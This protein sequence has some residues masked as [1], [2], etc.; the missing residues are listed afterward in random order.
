MENS[1][2]TVCESCNTLAGR[3]DGKLENYGQVADIVQTDSPLQVGLSGEVKGTPFVVTG[4]A[5]Y[6]HAAGGVWDE[7][8][9]AFHDGK[10][11]GW[12]AEAQ[13]K[14]YLTFPKQLP[15]DFAFDFAETPLEAE[16]EIP[17][18]GRMKV[19]E[20][21]QATA[22][23]AEGE[24]PY[25]FEPGETV[26]YADLQGSNGRFATIDNSD[27]SPSLYLGGEFSL[28]RLGVDPH[29]ASREEEAA[30][31]S[32]VGISCP[33]CGGALEQ[34]CPD[35]LR[36]VCP[37]CDSLLDVSAGGSLKFLEALGKQK[38]KPVIPLGTTGTLRGREYT[39]IGFLRRKVRSHGVDYPWQEYLLYTPREG[40]HWL[41]HS[42]SHWS[43][44]KPASAGDVRI[45]GHTC[46]YKD[47]SFR[48]FAKSVPM[49]THVLGEFYWE[50]SKGERVI[51][52]DYV[53]PPLMIS[54]EESDAR[55]DTAAEAADTAAQPGVGSREVAYTVSEYVPTKEVEQAFKVKGLRR[56]H[57]VAPN[58]PYPNKD[59]YPIA[60]VFAAATMVMAIAFFIMGSRK[61]LFERSFSLAP[62]T[63]AMAE[64]G[65]SGATNMGNG[66][67]FF[68]EE[69]IEIQ[70]G[71]N[72]QVTLEGNVDNSWIYLA[73]DF[74]DE[75]QGNTYPFTAEAAYY[76]GTSGGER[77][78]EG[79]RHKRRYV[80]SLPSG[81]YSLRLEFQ[82]DRVKQR[83]ATARVTIRQGVPRILNL[84]L[85]LVALS[86]VPI[87]VAVHHGMFEG[88][89]W[90]E[91]DFG[92]D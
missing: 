64:A 76:H 15:D 26:T 36:I 85:T 82:W 89:R 6:Q 32:S 55:A 28:E 83:N 79:S 38:I 49:V 22:V 25:Q 3:G 1:L 71:K 40:F 60:F 34:R 16:V 91:S 75:S 19:V 5:Q 29:A 31:V 33:N 4:R 62:S 46:K 20:I 87:G 81:K 48:L 68:P 56:P 52:A 24:I 39:V 78:S 92:G 61:V 44:G 47:Q 73:G 12:L 18:N 63:G 84:I 43:L 2:V 23:S 69:K 77:W 17:D 74:F 21:G 67:V 59:I 86:I 10:R 37:Y 70:G 11:W 57:G 51:S 41:I 50:V 53:A 65:P 14:Y 90:S 27:S 88:M 72:I 13:G 54:R 9:V 45:G 80:S 66:L 30:S 35:S 7:W 58:Q 42:E 8:Y